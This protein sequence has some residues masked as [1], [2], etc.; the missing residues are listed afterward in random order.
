MAAA[1][2]WGPDELMV[3]LNSQR[4]LCSP[5]QT[6]IMLSNVYTTVQRRRYITLANAAQF[7]PQINP[8]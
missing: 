5:C 8:T 1:R 2:E 7:P 3:R 6:S 4:P